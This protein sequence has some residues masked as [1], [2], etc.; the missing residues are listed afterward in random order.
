MESEEE[1]LRAA[2]E[3]IA[4][5]RSDC[6]WFLRDGLV[7]ADRSRIIELLRKIENHADRATFVRARSLRQWL[8]RNSSATSAGSYPPTGTNPA[9]A[10]WP[11]PRRSTS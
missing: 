1:V 5:H 9:K 6:L 10:M 4:E 7:P 3:L 2:R 11:A 8:L